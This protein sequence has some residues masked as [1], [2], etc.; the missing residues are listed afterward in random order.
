MSRASRHCGLILLTKLIGGWQEAGTIC[1]STG[2][3]SFI[4]TTIGILSYSVECLKC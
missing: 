2:G 1:V 3:A 4:M